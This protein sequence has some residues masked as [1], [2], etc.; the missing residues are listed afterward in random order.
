MVGAGHRGTHQKKLAC[1]AEI[2]HGQGSDSTNVWGGK[3]GP[4]A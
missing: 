3:Y 1:V 2:A 4:L